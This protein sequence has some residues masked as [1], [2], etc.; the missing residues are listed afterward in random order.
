MS[1]KEMS[2]SIVVLLVVTLLLC[3]CWT[4]AGVSGSDAT[5]DS[6]L[7][8]DTENI[9]QEDF[10]TGVGGEE[11]DDVLPPDTPADVPIDTPVPTPVPTPAPTPVP[12]PVPTPTPTP[13][14]VSTEPPV[15]QPEDEGGIVLPAIP[16]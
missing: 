2:L 10:T 12:T 7:P 5:G 8:G 4:Q 1:L 9:T 13:T 16:G 14:P 6:T 15:E 3:G 11:G